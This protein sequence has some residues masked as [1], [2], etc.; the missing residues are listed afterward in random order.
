M[1]NWNREQLVI[2]P[3]N[4]FLFRNLCTS[5]FMS[6]VLA[7]VIVSPTVPCKNINK[8]NRKKALGFCIAYPVRNP[9]HIF[10][11]CVLHDAYIWLYCTLKFF[12][13]FVVTLTVRPPGKG[14]MAHF[15]RNLSVTLQK[16]LYLKAIFEHWTRHSYIYREGFV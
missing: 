1:L 5:P 3:Q 8:F 4:P 14:T 2:I 12:R 7:W 9:C 11:Y 13:I 16:C 6:I 15:C 10:C